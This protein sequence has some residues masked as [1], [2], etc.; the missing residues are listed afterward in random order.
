MKVVPWRLKPGD[1]LRLALKAWIGKQ[2]ESAGCVLIG[3]GRLSVAE[4]RI[5]GQQESTTIRGNLEIL[6]LTGTPSANDAHLHIA[7]ADSTGAVVLG[8]LPEW[9]FH[10]GLDP[11]TGYAEL[12]ISPR[13]P[14]AEAAAAVPPAQTPARPPRH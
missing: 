1:D 9:E 7:V 11:A 3:M 2:G 10:R 4:L 5:A 13:A 14:G 12:Q 6:S 8:L